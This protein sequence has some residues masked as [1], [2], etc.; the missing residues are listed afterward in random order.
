M[1][2]GLK[3]ID[4]M[5]LLLLPLLLP[6]SSDF[7]WQTT[8][9]SGRQWAPGRNCIISCTYVDLMDLYGSTPEGHIQSDRML[10]MD[11]NFVGHRY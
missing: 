9:P 5:M 10:A 1:A 7:C 3:V 2:E 6:L 8:T 11:T 4:T